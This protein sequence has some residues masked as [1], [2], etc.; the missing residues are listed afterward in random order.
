[1]VSAL[2]RGR[3]APSRGS[4]AKRKA[5]R[6]A[7]PCTAAD[8]RFRCMVDQDVSVFPFGVHGTK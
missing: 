8:S 7:P 6:C 4:T 1:M 5:E 2:S 3:K